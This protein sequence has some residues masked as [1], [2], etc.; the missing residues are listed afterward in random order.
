MKNSVVSFSRFMV[1]YYEMY[2]EDKITISA[3]KMASPAV[4]SI[5]I[6]KILP[7]IKEIHMGGNLED[8]FGLML[9]H[10]H[11]EGAVPPEILDEQEKEKV[12]VG[13]GSGFIVKPNGIILTNKHVV[14]D[15]D[16][17]YVVITSDDKEYP[18]RVLTRDLIN[19]VAIL[20][21][22][23]KNMPVVQLGDSAKIQPGQTVLAIGNAL[24]LFSNTVSKGIISGLS[25]QISA[26]TG[27]GEESEQ[28]RGVIQT[29]VAINQGNSGGP[30]ISLDG[31][32]VGIN[33]AVIF[34]AQNI[35]FAIP[36]NRA[37]KDLDDLEKYGRIVQ[38]FIGLRYVMLSAAIKE[39]YNLATDYGALVVRDHIPGSH[40]I[41]PKSPADKAGIKEN[42]VILEIN[43]E[44]LTEKNDLSDVVQ[45]CKVGHEIGLTILRKDKT[46]QTKTVLEERR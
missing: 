16:A 13:G 4:V 8:V 37:K 15:A 11:Q 31:E 19:D 21:I 44:K 35:G 46:I 2:S 36:I 20:K 38:P 10:Q 40:A 26:A 24:G 14:F 5:V 29:D 18:A 27:T 34:G 42:D 28:L 7:K 25:R 12:T 43:G 6:S 41:V 3:A 33:T 45:K 30:L 23:A 32:V 1:K 39:K 9:P 22:D 17:E